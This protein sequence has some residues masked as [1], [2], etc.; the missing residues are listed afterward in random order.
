MTRREKLVLDFCRRSVLELLHKPKG[1]KEKEKEM[2]FY[3][4]RAVVGAIATPVIAGAYF[5]FYALLVGAGADPTNTP[6]GVWANGIMIGVV[7]AVAFTFFPQLVK[8]E[9]KIY[10]EVK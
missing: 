9:K 5:V 4:R 6:Q 2:K 1:R 7:L 3:I 8:L 10:G